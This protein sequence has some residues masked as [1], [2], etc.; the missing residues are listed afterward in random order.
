MKNKNQ[1]INILPEDIIISEDITKEKEII[2]SNKITASRYSF[3]VMEKRAI[4]LIAM[5]IRKD[6]EGEKK[7]QRD[8]IGDVYMQF[9]PDQV[10][11]ASDRYEHVYKALR[12]LSNKKIEVNNDYMW[13]EVGIV[14]RPQHYKKEG[15]F[16]FKVAKPILDYFK[17]KLTKGNATVL[18][19]QVAFTLER[20]SSQRLY[21]LCRQF[22]VAGGFMKTLEEFKAQMGLTTIVRYTRWANLKKDFIEPAQKEIKK[23]YDDGLCDLYFN[24]KEITR[25]KRVNGI[26][27]KIVNK[28]KN[29]FKEYRPE[30]FIFFCREW[31]NK[32]FEA[33]KKPKNKEFVEKV[34]KEIML[35]PLRAEELHK[36][37][38]RVMNSYSVNE[39]PAIVRS[40]IKEDEFIRENN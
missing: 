16:Q 19:A 30:D 2:Q 14:E 33:K 31:L 3:T 17:I 38:L 34:M 15:Y 6:I 13:E 10:L 25:G 12:D 1:T 32:M 24:Y 36:K 22:K 20:T 40:I 5:N 7:L 8:L 21:E 28:D 37:L 18:S 39:Q 29:P 35:N 23:L 26:R 9:T 27:F 4:Y 11:K